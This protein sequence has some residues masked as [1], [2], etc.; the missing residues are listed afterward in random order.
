MGLFFVPVADRLIGR[1][2]PDAAVFSVEVVK[3]KP[4]VKVVFHLLGVVVGVNFGGALL[5]QTIG[6]LHHS[7]GFGCVG[8]GL[9]MLNLVVLA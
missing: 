8:S 3:D 9:A 7:I 5:D 2:A 6:S 4:G 1:D